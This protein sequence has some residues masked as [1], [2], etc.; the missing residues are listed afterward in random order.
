MLGQ[1]NSHARQGNPGSPGK[2]TYSLEKIEGTHPGKG[3]SEACNGRDVSIKTKLM[4]A[5]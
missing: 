4:S 1:R 3:A 2:A 5:H